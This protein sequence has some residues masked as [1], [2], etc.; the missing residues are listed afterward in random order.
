MPA[1]QWKVIQTWKENG[2]TLCLA[3]CIECEGL[4]FRNNAYCERCNGQGTQLSEPG[5][6]TK[7]ALSRIE[8]PKNGH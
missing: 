1:A 5:E 3:K 7:P 6:T 8:V 2:K 4:G